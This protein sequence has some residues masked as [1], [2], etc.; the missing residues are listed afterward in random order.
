MDAELRGN[1]PGL[2]GHS[3]AN[4]AEILL[5][6]LDAVETRSVVEI[7]AFEGDLTR[8][9]L[10]WAAGA[11]ARVV[12]IEPKPPALLLELAEEHPELELVRKT[13]HEALREIPLPDTVIVDGD[14]NYYTVREELRLIEDRAGTEL[15]LL[16]FHDVGWPHGR[17]DTYYAPEQIP[18]DYLES[19]S[20]GG[21]VFPGE[22]GLADGG[23]PYRWLSEREGGPRNGVLTAVE[24][25]VSGRD[26]VRLAIVPAFFGLGVVWQRQGPRAGAVAEIVERWD[27]NPILARLEANRVFQLANEHVR[28][29]EVARLRERNRK[30]ERLLREM[31][32]SRPFAL[33]DRLSGLRWGGRAPSWREQ[34]RD[35]LRNDRPS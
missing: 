12:A 2:W 5:P 21:H 29:A 34:V 17:R 11:D 16:L 3:L 10:A 9:L 33:A 30:Q 1:D 28:R 20:P 26:D 6:L 22:C 13:S 8:E 7:G 19:V 25:F 18:D 14:H 4:M 23:L 27:R 32:R 31:L 24:D 35:A 15:P